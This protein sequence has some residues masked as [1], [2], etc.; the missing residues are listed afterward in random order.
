MKFALTAVSG[1][2]L[3]NPLPRPLGWFTRHALLISLAACGLAGVIRAQA[4]A[5]SV[6]LRHDGEALELGNDV[7]RVRCEVGE[8]R[9]QQQFFAR[10]VGSWSLVGQSFRPPR[11]FPPDGNQLF[12]NDVDAQRWLVSE[13]LSSVEAVNADGANP[14]IRL[15]GTARDAEIEQTITLKPGD[16]HFHLQVSARIPGTPP[17]LDFL[18]STFTFELSRIPEF[19]HTPTLKYTE[20]RWPG[21]ARDQ[22]LGDRCFH[23][24][25]VILQ[26]AGLF[27]ALV[28]DLTALNAD[29]VVSPDA[30]RQ[31]H[32]PRN[33]FSVP[34]EADK[35]TLPSALDLNVVSGITPKP[36]L[37]F[38]LMDYVIAHHIRYL[39]SN[40]TMMVRTLAR[41][42][43]RYAFD[44]FVS[45]DA[46]AQRGYQDVTRFQWERY[47]HAVFAERPHL[48]M[49]FAEYVRLTTDVTLKPLGAVHP[50]VP[51]LR[52][53]GSFLFFDL[54]GQ[55]VGGYRSAAPFM[56]D[57]LSNSE[58]WNNVRDAVGMY[59]WGKRT[60]TTQLV[61]MAQRTINL[62]LLA[63]Q[64]PCGMFPLNY[65][66]ASG[67]W[68]RSMFTAAPGKPAGLF[69]AVDAE[70]DTYDVV[71]MSRTATH[72]LR[73]Y[74]RCVPDSRILAYVT[75]YADGLLPLVDAEG[76]VPSYVSAT[77][78]APYAPLARS[79]QD[80]TTLQ[81]L[82]E[83]AQLTN[84]TRYLDAARR[85]GD[86]LIREVLPRQLWI[87]LE[88]YY[89][90]GAKPLE[91]TGDREQGQPARGNLSTLWAADGF[92]AL[93][94]ATRDKRYL[95]AGERC[96]D[97]LTFSQ[98][99]W[100]PHFI[101]TAFP[102]G[103]FTA[104]NADTATF[105]DARQAEAV[106]PFAWY[107]RTLGRQDLLERAV[108][109]ARSSV[110]LINHPRHQ[111]VNNIYRHTN[112]YPLGLG[113]ENIDHEG[114]PQSAM[115]TSPS[116]GEASGVFT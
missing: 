13:V 16:R 4:A 78:H 19:V 30:R 95:D 98:C 63:P 80:G 112:L 94:R 28:P 22:V 20:Q 58:F 47:G 113:P 33:Q 74:Q 39:R 67:R 10:Q 15:H 84:H 87:D 24:P 82:A 7:V 38:G 111:G 115:R 49:P 56:L 17:K 9:V 73:Y 35:Y 91:F 54:Q 1:Y 88:Q 97:Y 43:V 86:R 57:N 3:L 41:S 11:P 44:L 96:I 45:A 65:R 100:E 106:A 75:R 52:D 8:H 68:V 92:A 108:A 114:H 104:D 2:E 89:S 70:G 60:G 105:L 37:S 93:Y 48:A 40:D 109:A 34:V 85:I 36:I 102:F 101:Y 26:E 29:R 77:N 110:V 103:G 46:P 32:V 6:W 51:G 18:L 107:G 53:T 31:M 5:D 66:A 81:L 50:P 116:W 71:A 42:G 25:A 55:P 83:L 61:D 69:S 21:P 23:A 76:V 64:D 59:E 62:A 99:C 12:Q 14:C 27:A 72:L 79:A 90:C